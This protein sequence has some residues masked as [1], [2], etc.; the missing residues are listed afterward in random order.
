MILVTTLDENA[1]CPNC[2]Q[3]NALLFDHLED[4]GEVL[5]CRNCRVLVRPIPAQEEGD[6]DAVPYGC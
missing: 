3:Y 2:K 6:L 4:T 5:K 1:S